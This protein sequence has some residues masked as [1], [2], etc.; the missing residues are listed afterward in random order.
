MIAK[1]FAIELLNVHLCCYGF[2]NEVDVHGAT[3]CHI[4]PYSV[5]HQIFTTSWDSNISSPVFVVL[6]RY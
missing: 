6:A 1:T 4:H 3:E 2:I 5:F